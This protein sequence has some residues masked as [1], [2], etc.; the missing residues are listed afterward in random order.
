MRFFYADLRS[1]GQLAGKSAAIMTRKTK[2][3]A[4]RLTQKQRVMLTELAGSSTAP[5]RELER[6]KG[7]LGYADGASITDLMPVD[8]Q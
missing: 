2:R 8:G 6:A 1:A 7:L 4:L 5:V 3:T